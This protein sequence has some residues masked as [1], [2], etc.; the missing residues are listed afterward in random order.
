MSHKFY[1]YQHLRDHITSS[2]NTY[3]L[4]KKNKNVNNLSIYTKKNHTWRLLN[5]IYDMQ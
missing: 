1:K 5:E 3:I 4:N 2:T